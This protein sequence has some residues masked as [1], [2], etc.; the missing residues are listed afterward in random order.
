MVSENCDRKSPLKVLLEFRRG[1]I[2]HEQS[3]TKDR[4]MS[5][6]L[7]DGR[8]LERDARRGKEQTA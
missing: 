2:M 8:I 6:I 3:F 4:N 5:E 1:A 7:K